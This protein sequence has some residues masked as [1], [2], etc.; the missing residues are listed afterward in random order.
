MNQKENKLAVKTGEILQKKVRGIPFKKGHDERRNLNGHPEGQK[1]FNTL[2][3]DAF[4]KIV[5]EKKIANLTNPEIE[6]VV[7][8]VIEALKGNYKFFEYI[9]NKKYGKPTEAIDITTKGESINPLPAG[10]EVPEEDKQAVEEFH[11][12]LESNMLK[13]VLSKKDENINR[14]SADI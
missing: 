13:R 9:M 14:E 8:G 2:L 7:K 6:M 12:K 5:T 1:N 3:D 10:D 4:K 11:A